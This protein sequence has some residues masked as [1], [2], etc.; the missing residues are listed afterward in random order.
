MFPTCRIADRLDTL[1]HPQHTLDAHSCHRCVLLAFVRAA[2]PL[3]PDALGLLPGHSFHKGN[4]Y[5]AEEALQS[6]GSK[7]AHSHHDTSNTTPDLLDTR[8]EYMPLVPS[9]QSYLTCRI[10]A[11]QFAFTNIPAHHLHGLMS[12]LP[13]NIPLRHT[14]CS[15][16]GRKSCS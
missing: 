15:C 6:T 1:A 7:S 16:R 10:I 4:H 5:T 11:E 8:I 9:L 12:R 14:R 2:L 13:H 3:L